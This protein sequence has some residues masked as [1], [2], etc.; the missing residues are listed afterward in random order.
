MK[1]EKTDGRKTV[2]DGNIGIRLPGLSKKPST[3]LKEAPD[4]SLKPGTLRLN[5]NDSNTLP[6][7]Q[8]CGTKR[9]EFMKKNP[10]STI[11][12]GDR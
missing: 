5:I 1:Q 11:V 12:R 2:P 6:S 10:R 4:L 8:V 7:L 9:G 3:F